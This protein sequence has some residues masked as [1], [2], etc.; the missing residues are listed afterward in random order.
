MDEEIY[1]LLANTYGCKIKKLGTHKDVFSVERKKRIGIKKKVLGIF[2]VYEY[3]VWQDTLS[4]WTYRNLNMRNNFT[5]KVVYSVSIAI[6]YDRY[7][8]TCYWRYV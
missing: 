3:E 2:P 8:N 4:N 1:E 7:G 5:G 6:C